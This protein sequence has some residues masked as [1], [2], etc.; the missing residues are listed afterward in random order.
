MDVLQWHVQV[1]EVYIEHQQNV[2]TQ[3]ERLMDQLKKVLKIK[4]AQVAWKLFFNY[5]QVFNVAVRVL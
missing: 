3:E 1:N 2:G 4:M 5:L